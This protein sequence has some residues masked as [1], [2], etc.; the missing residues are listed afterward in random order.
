MAG[1]G[2]R[3]SVASQLVVNEIQTIRKTAQTARTRRTLVFGSDI[4]DVQ[5]IGAATLARTRALDD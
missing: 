5:I 2:P 3:P 4:P 1:A